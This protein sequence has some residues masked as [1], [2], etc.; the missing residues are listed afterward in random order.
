MVAIDLF[1]INAFYLKKSYVKLNEF[2]TSDGVISFLKNDTT[3]YRGALSLSLPQG[4]TPAPIPTTALRGQYLT[5]LFP[6]YDIESID[7]PAVSRMDPYYGKYFIDTLMASLYNPAV[8]NVTNLQAVLNGQS[9]DFTDLINLNIRL[10]QLANV[11]YLVTD[12]YPIPQRPDFM[13]YS[14]FSNTNV[15]FTNSAYGVNGAPNYTFYVKNVLPRAGYFENFVTVQNNDD[16]L[17]YITSPNFNFHN[18]V[19]VN[20]TVPPVIDNYNE[21]VPLTPLEYKPWYA[22]YEID[23]PKAGVLLHNIKYDPAWKAFIDGQPA[24][25]F[26]ANFIAQ[27]VFVEAGKHTR[28][29]QVYAGLEAVQDLAVYQPARSRGLRRADRADFA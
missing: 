16:A 29:V 11:K 2:Y 28:R 5:Y 7:V 25:I 10:F 6:Y 19:L 17:T 22:K 21:V 23:F 18:L 26:K 27:G 15:I 13:F 14:L 3:Q 20:S 1:S 9:Y 12:G 24:T 8:V 4:N